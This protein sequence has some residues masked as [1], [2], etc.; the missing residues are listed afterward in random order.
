MSPTLLAAFS[1][2]FRHNS[3]HTIRY[4]YN[5]R[6]T[7]ILGMK[8]DVHAWC[9]SGDGCLSQAGCALGYHHQIRYSRPGQHRHS[10]ESYNCQLREARAQQTH[11]LQFKFG[12]NNILGGPWPPWLSIVPT[13]MGQALRRDLK[14]PEASKWMVLRLHYHCSL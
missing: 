6:H 11:F 1:I 7:I 8:L 9:M 12:V 2:V 3:R 4:V 13:P 10:E 5:S 14:T